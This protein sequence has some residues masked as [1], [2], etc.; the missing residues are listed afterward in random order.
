[1]L[2]DSD[3][4]IQ[5]LD[6]AQGD[7]VFQLDKCDNPTPMALNYLGKFLMRPDPLAL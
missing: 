7:L 2:D 6:E 4:V 3:L 1:M 5:S